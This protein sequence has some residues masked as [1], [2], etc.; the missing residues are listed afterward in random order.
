[1]L[2]NLHTNMQIHCLLLAAILPWPF[3]I[4]IGTKATANHNLEFVAWQPFTYKMAAINRQCNLHLCNN[5]P[6][7]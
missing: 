1:M 7:N 3:K 5:L 2:L 4:V 6:E